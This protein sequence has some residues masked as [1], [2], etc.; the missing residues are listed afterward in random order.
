MRRSFLPLFVILLASG[1]GVT[2][3][4][5][6]GA[7]SVGL[8]GGGMVFATG[9][10]AVEWN[11]ANLAWGGGWNISLF[12]LGVVGIGS[13]TT[14]PD[15]ISIMEGGSEAPSLIAA[16]PSDGISLALI[17][18]GFGTAYLLDAL[19][20]LP[21]GANTAPLAMGSPLPSVG[22][23][24]GPV[25]IRIR[26][27]FRQDFTLSKELA[28]LIGNGFELAN[29][30]NYAVGNTG[31]SSVSTSEVTLSYGLTIG[32]ALSLGVGGRYVMGHG[33]T[34]GRFFEPQ[35]DLSCL[36]GD[37]NCEVM[38]LQTASVE[39]RDGIGYGLDIGASLALPMGFRVAA[40]GTNVVQRMEWDE[41]QIIGYHARYTDADFDDD[42][43]LGLGIEDYL[44]RFSSGEVLDPN[45]VSL[46]V[47]E[48][49]QG[50]LEGS[51]F[52]QV[53]R[54][55]LGWRSGGTTLEAVG[56]KVAPRGRYASVWDERVSVGLEQKLPL[57]T[58]RGGYG[59]AE[60]GI[61]QLTGGVGLRLGPVHIDV[62]GGKFSGERLDS[63]PWDGYFGTVGLQI[64]AG[65]Q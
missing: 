24:V 58:L 28:D 7:R 39:A 50:F 56:I 37:P 6:P 43:N 55:G 51:Y 42:L 17:T 32:E 48:A 27:R 31:W 52:P 26:S 12:E 8:G 47:Y 46:A 62:S 54:A 35:V 41:D 33:M 1:Q 15:F 36:A 20:E 2:A 64:R 53:F 49:S 18:E 22:L 3:Q 34:Q 65:G 16:L 45:S 61:T 60:N 4:M 23:A 30:Q 14:V 10:D 59:F 19:D 40:S 38:V 25:A 63:A 11:P 9:V 44:D 57:L 21:N 13:G 5:S 29:V